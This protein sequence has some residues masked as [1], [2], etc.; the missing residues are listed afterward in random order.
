MIS[1]RSFKV[2]AGKVVRF[3]EQANP[4]DYSSISSACLLV[5]GAVNKYFDTAELRERFKKSDFHSKYIIALSNLINAIVARDGVKPTA[6]TAKPITKK[7]VG[8][9]TL[10]DPDYFKSK[11]PSRKSTSKTRMVSLVAAKPKASKP[12]V[13]KPKIAKVKLDKV[14]KSPT[15][16]VK[17][18]KVDIVFSFDDT[19]SMAACRHTT[20]QLV[21]EI[22]AE[23]LVEFGD[24]LNVGVMI[25]GDYCDPGDPL[26]TLPMTRDWVKIKQFLNAERRFQG[27]DAPECYELVLRDV[28]KLDW[29]VNSHKIL[30]LIG[31][32]LPHE[33]TYRYNTDHIDWRS[34]VSGL[35]AMGVQVIAVQAL[36]N[37]YADNFYRD[38]AAKTHG[39][40]LRLTQLNQIA[41]LIRAIC[42]N[43]LGQLK[44]FEDKN[45]NS[46][47]AFKRNLDVLAGREAEVKTID[48]LSDFQMFSIGPDDHD[49]RIRDFVEKM[50]MKYTPGC[51]YYEFTKPETVQ[52]Y[53][54]VVVQDRDTEL[55]YPDV[56]GRA[57][58]KLPKYGSVRINPR[59]YDK[60][61]RFFIQST[62]YTRKL[63]S[64]TTF[65]YDNR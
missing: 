29:R 36:N 31:D 26:V 3:V 47:P 35:H 4:K 11:A 27:G 52:D 59:D 21:D 37:R 10:A 64:D 2:R 44:K 55:F 30:V 61:Y 33:K 32:D 50:G 42:Y 13:S 45:K 38:V 16:D 8:R 6:D 17:I 48:G 62:S 22:S 57:L 14:A 60:K 53:K 40:H 15:F 1:E 5:D 24:K 43:S 63:K 54:K 7:L 51:G 39:H 34:E 9:A 25:H 28:Q 18:G 65:L 56:E 23:L 58:L 41:D 49:I 19:G 46:S 20:R 12:K